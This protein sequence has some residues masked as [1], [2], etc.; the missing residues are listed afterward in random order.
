MSLSPIEQFGPFRL[1]L[2]T[3][4][5]YAIVAYFLVPR[6][7]SGQSKTVQ[8]LLMFGAPIVLWFVVY[9]QLKGVHSLTMK[10]RSAAERKMAEAQE[11][12]KK[13]PQT[14]GYDKASRI[15]ALGLT[16]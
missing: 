13:G 2:A 8:R 7:F 15:V 3:P 6:I 1:S 9:R 4:I 5:M 16:Y 14:P 11:I 10:N 12:I